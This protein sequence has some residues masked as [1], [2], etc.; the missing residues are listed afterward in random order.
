MANNVYDPL[1]SAYSRV[2]LIEGRASPVNVPS[3]MSQLKAT[4]ITRNFGDTTKIEMPDPVNYGKF[5]EVDSIRGVTERATSSLVGKYALNLKSKLLQL[6][7]QGCAVDIQVHM[8]KCT[9][10]S[11]FNSFSKSLIFESVIVGSWTTEDLG[12]ISSDENAKVDETA[13]IS[14]ANVYE[15]VPLLYQSRSNDVV[16]NP[17]IDIKVIDYS[18]CGDCGNASDGC[19]QIFAISKAAGGSP[20]TPADVIFSTNK[21]ATFKAHD[22]DSMNVASDGSSIFAV[23]DNIVAVS[24]DENALFYAAKADIIGGGDPLFVKITSG[25]VYKPLYGC[26]A[27]RK[28]FIA[29][30]WGYIYLCENAAAG[31]TVLEASSITTSNLNHVYAYDENNAVAVGDSGVVLYTTNQISWSMAPTVPIGIAVN[32]NCVFMKSKT[33]WIVA[34]SD[35]KLYYTINSGTTWISKVMPGTAPSAMTHVA[36]STNSVG[37]ASGTV[38]GKGKLYRTFDGGYSWVVVPS[39]GGTF[40]NTT[41]ITRL[42]TCMSDPNFVAAGGQNFPTAADGIIIIGS[43]I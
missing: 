12:A 26:S 25:F 14:A 39:S 27:G 3:Y 4:G 37:F 35:G 21:G 41:E 11:S 13:E 17:V 30:M 7:T 22:I 1:K 24:K 9:D 40:V 15:V 23:G 36:F 32:L 29:G 19:Y 43:S 10:P 2:F 42:A 5:I 20:T 34:A 33:E 6:A 31:V 38:S 28:A 8:G 18:S 16:T